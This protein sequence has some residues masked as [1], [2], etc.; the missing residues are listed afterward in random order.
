[1]GN[2]E[3][4]S[5][6]ALQL[7]Y[8]IKHI[9]VDE[10]QDTDLVQY[11]IIKMLAKKHRNI[12]VVADDDQ[13]IYA[14]RGA[15]PENIQTYM[16]DFKIEAPLFLETN[17]RS[18]QKIIDAAHL[19]VKDTE[20]VEPD[21]ILKPGDVVNDSVQT[22]F[23]DNEQQ[24]LEFIYKKMDLWHH[25]KHI[26][27]SEMAVLYPQ[28]RFAEQ[29]ALKL[30]RERIPFQQATGRN[31]SDN[32]QMKK[33]ILYLQVIRDPLDSLFLEA[34]VE[35]ELGYNPHIQ[36][37]NYQRKIKSTYRKALYELS[38][39]DEIGPDFQRVLV[40]FIGN[41]A[42]LINLKTFYTFGQLIEQ[43][44][45]GLQDLDNSY[46]EEKAP[47]FENFPMK[48]DTHFLQS[49]KTIWVYHL[50]KQF[51]FIA[52]KIAENIFHGKVKTVTKEN[53]S[54]LHKSDFVLLLSP[55]NEKTEAHY[56]TLFLE[57][58]TRRESVFSTLIRWCQNHLAKRDTVFGDYVVFDLETTGR[59]PNKC[60]VVEIA[61]VKV[62]H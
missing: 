33:I 2:I 31:F 18:G 50:E 44:I 1:L 59:N 10:F 60:G 57:T 6:L 42:N 14:W 46:I 27:Y 23:F 5:D 12:F 37:Q 21:K 16:T 49:R 24:E 20:R 9:F 55:L 53:F 19:I 25:E 8:Q 4:P 3:A 36:I 38:A 52:Q 7:D 43:I 39:Q 61:A 22:Q 56:F 62:K 28:H 13:S 35:S 40:T 30:I 17:Y 51:A 34:L 29:I 48:N 58:N 54:A 26:P 11:E 45:I 41:L 15:N 32:P 47:K